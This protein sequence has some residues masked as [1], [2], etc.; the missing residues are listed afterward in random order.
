MSAGRFISFEGL[1]GSG[2][3]TQLERLE[4]RLRGA[5]HDPVVTREPGATALGLE[6]RRLLLQPTTRPMCAAAELLLYAADR[7]QHLH[8]VV[9]PA[10]ARGHV[11]LCDRHVDAS[12]AY[13]GHAR[14][15]GAEWILRIHD[16]DSLRRRP[17]RTLLFDLD[18]A[19]ALERARAR[20]RRR[21]RAHD[22]GRFEDEALAFHERVREGYLALAVAEPQRVRRIDARGS[23]ERVEADV[24]GQ[25]DDLLPELGSGA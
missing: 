14:D 8:E 4:R 7:A 10:L 3:S 25:L 18:P 23:V 9:E 17:D 20:D 21:G 19:T 12:L 16:H 1:E 6:L 22:E 5:G 11:V 15:L 2:K 24:H 13:Q